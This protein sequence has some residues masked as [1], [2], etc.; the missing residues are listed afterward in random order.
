MGENM[1][2]YNARQ[3]LKTKS[4][5]DLELK[6]VY[7]ARVSTDKEEQ[8][9][10]IINQKSHFEEF[11]RSNKHWKFAGGYIDDG[12]SGIHAEKR[13][14]FQKMIADAKLGKFDLIITKE[15]SR[16]ARN[17]LDSIRYT[18]QLLSHGVCVWFQ[19]DNINTIDDDSEFR[20]TIMAG[21]AQDE[22]RKLSSRVRFGHAQAIKNGVVL[23]NSRLYGYDK[24][25]GRLTINE[26]E[27]P[28]IRLIFEKYSS[29]DWSTPKIEKLL[30]DM[31]YRNYNGGKI[32]RGVI[33]HII[34]NPK[35]KGWYA[36]GKVKIVDMFTKK[37]EFLPEEEWNLYKDDGS[38]VPAI[39]DEKTWELANR[40]FEMRSN[41]IKSRRTSFKNDNLFT[42][43]I[44]CA[45]D[46]APYWMK[47]HYVRGKE[48]VKWVCSY[49]I[50]NGAASCSSFGISEHELKTMIANII[51]QSSCSIEK[52]SKEY[53]ELYRKV[54]LR[55]T[56][57]HTEEIQ[58][59]EHQIVKIQSKMD[60]ILDYNLD[61]KISDDEFL[62][63]NSEFNSQIKEL[64]ERMMQ[65]SAKPESEIEIER[66][67]MN[68]S[69]KIMHFKGVESSD[70]DRKIVDC[71]LNK[72]DVKPTG[73]RTASIRFY[74]NS[75]EE[76]SLLYDRD[77]LS[78]SGN[79]F[80]IML[81]EQHT[82]F[83]RDLRSF[84][85][86]KMPINYNYAF[87]I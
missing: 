15:I 48:D 5:Y 55:E 58:K 21:V 86:H 2:I 45:N 76:K 62:R 87:A 34:Q 42:G 24:E 68:I 22:V 6:V 37:Q 44:F 69:E 54:I 31:G 36:G 4:I 57:D 28:M 65:L 72:I 66:K 27:A 56:I 7:Y 8:K 11:I 13:E 81:P 75:G 32:S 16:F 47:Q 82:V 79:I 43:K 53:L 33:N 63:R 38:T 49:R 3:L 83:Y 18:R 41:A 30:W 26:E 52:L 1:N 25:N 59:I 70:I 61:G 60:K 84:S 20:L 12:I 40:Y 51:N 9:N 77:L 67:L 14:K 74:I 29:G 39:V 64:K 85:G 17:T 73:E 35:Y 23:G 50:K 71:L 19:N 80:K 10:S 78:C 46:G